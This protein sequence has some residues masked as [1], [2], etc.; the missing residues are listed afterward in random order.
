MNIYSFIQTPLSFDDP[1]PILFTIAMIVGI[2]SIIWLKLRH[3]P[4]LEDVQ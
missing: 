4:L 2:V 3:P 1:V